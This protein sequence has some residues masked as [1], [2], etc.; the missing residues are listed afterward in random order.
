MCLLGRW[1]LFTRRISQGIRK[2]GWGCRG[3][4]AGFRAGL[5]WRKEHPE[6][7]R[8]CLRPERNNEGE[9]SAQKERRLVWSKAVFLP[10]DKVA[11]SS[12]QGGVP[13]CPQL[14]LDLN[15]ASRWEAGVDSA[16]P[17]LW[18]AW[19]RSPVFMEIFKRCAKQRGQRRML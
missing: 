5:L 16:A 19:V 17:G 15:N 1:L 2:P 14:S 3:A 11:H 18:A 10:G 8:G 7:L 6:L 9:A 13:R 12:Q 4:A